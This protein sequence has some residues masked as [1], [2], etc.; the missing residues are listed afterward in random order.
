MARMADVADLAAF[1]AQL[2]DTAGLTNWEITDNGSGWLHLTTTVLIPPSTHW[3]VTDDG[4][5]WLHLTTTVLP[6]GVDP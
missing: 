5:G 2:P 1:L 4:S 6:E 3:E